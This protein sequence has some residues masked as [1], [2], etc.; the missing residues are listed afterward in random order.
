MASTYCKSSLGRKSW[1]R[2]RGR[3]NRNAVVSPCARPSGREAGD[4]FV[5]H[6]EFE[7]FEFPRNVDL[8]TV[9]DVIGRPGF[10]RLSSERSC[11]KSTN[12]K[13]RAPFP[14][15]LEDRE[16]LR[17][18][19]S[20]VYPKTSRELIP[21]LSWLKKY[22]NKNIFRNKPSACRKSTPP[23]TTQTNRSV[24]S[25]LRD[26]GMYLQGG[27]TFTQRQGHVRAVQHETLLLPPRLWRR[28]STPV[29]ETV[30]RTE[31][32]RPPRP[33]VFCNLQGKCSGSNSRKRFEAGGGCR[34]SSWS[35]GECIHTGAS[36][37]RGATHVY[38]GRQWWTPFP[39][40]LLA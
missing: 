39:P 3:W 22:E 21:R 1:Q 14:F 13:L 19:W 38:F 35:L 7:L 29:M 27:P 12:E 25:C 20:W 30:F 31:K 11:Q 16:T 37:W 26:H 36:L 40:Q 28:R 17:L 2:L 24:S 32:D 10:F 4:Q 6:G 8:R 34:E 23:R 15:L 18:G 5:N 9:V 33:Q